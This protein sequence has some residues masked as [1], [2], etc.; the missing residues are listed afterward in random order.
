MHE[1]A[2]AT[3]L[4]DAIE[5][6]AAHCFDLAAEIPLRVA[7]FRVGVDEH[8]LVGVVHHIAAD[9]WSI[10]PLVTDLN[11]AYA[12][13]CAG[14]EPGWTELPLQYPDFTLWQRT[15]LGDLDDSASLI[16]GQLGYW[17]HS[18]AGLPERLQLPTD[19]PYPQVA[20]HRGATTDVHWPAE[21]Q[22]G[23]REVARAHNVTTFMV[24]E[25]ALAVLLARLGATDDVAIG[26]PIAGRS[27]PALDGLI[28]FFVNTVVLRVDLADDPTVADL[29]ARVRRNS[30]AAYEHQDVPFEVLV[31]TLNPTR[32]L[33]HHPLIQV[34]LAWSTAAA[35]SGGLALG[36][37]D[38]TQL[39][40]E[41]QT[42][43]MDLVF[44]LVERVTGAG[45]PAGIDGTVEFRT[46]VFDP[47]TV[48]TLIARLQRVLTAMTADPG[49]RLSDID[50]LDPGERDRIDRFGNGAALTRPAERRPS[51]P[52]LFG[53]HVAATPEAVAKTVTPRRAASLTPRAAAETCACPSAP[54]SARCSTRR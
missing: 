47:G 12:A 22:R 43:R 3:R 46:D 19:R 13:R 35:D 36:D 50:L 7:L 24:I 1:V 26:F 37:L 53:R 18:L 4:A 15:R 40:I 27:D 30:L 23:L 10:T 2:A 49:R 31:D 28:G 42:A 17:R 21:L 8:V 34:A 5:R 44:S 38:I 33:T 16:A 20:D 39:P 6:A 9:G 25:A 29:L 45:E 41:T 32:S 48:E 11:T 51:I 14:Q 52:A 54:V